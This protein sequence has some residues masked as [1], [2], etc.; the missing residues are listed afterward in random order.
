MV[1]HAE[2]LRDDW[3]AQAARQKECYGELNKVRSRLRF[4][5]HSGRRSKI[6]LR[7][8]NN[9]PWTRR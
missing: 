5:L 9:S 8:S 6:F 2:M 4:H 1:E 3:M 7:G